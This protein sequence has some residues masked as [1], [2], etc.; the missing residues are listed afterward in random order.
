MRPSRGGRTPAPGN[1]ARSSVTVGKNPA[2]SPE[3]PSLAEITGKTPRIDPPSNE[4]SS[5]IGSSPSPSRQKLMELRESPTKR[6][7]KAPPK[8]AAKEPSNTD[9]TSATSPDA[10]G[11]SGSAL[12]AAL[13]AQAL[14]KQELTPEQQA[15]LRKL[16]R[17]IRWN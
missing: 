12:A 4:N 10:N 17:I 6:K 11:E 13:E 16:D 2:T 9:L 8:I 5:T 1:S 15:L 7:R 3:L 14:N